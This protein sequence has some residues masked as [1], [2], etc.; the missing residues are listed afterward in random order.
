MYNILCIICKVISND[1]NY[2]S[3]INSN[4]ITEIIFSCVRSLKTFDRFSFWIL[5]TRNNVNSLFKGDPSM[6][7]TYNNIVYYLQ[8]NFE[9]LQLCS[10]D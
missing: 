7:Y 3:T 2:A 5:D 6:Y 4:S 1:Y 9:R 8:G 10:N